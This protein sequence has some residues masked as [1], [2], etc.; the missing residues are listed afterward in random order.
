[1][2]KQAK[3]G[4]TKPS[5]PSVPTGSDSGPATAAD[6]FDPS[7]FRLVRADGLGLGRVGVVDIGSNTLRLVVYDVPTRLPIPMYNEKAQC[8][9]GRGMAETGKLYGPGVE[10]ALAS[11]D[12]FIRLAE[13]MGVRDLHLVATAAVRDASDG[14]E[15]VDTIYRRFARRVEVLSGAEEAQLAALGLLSGTR[16][17]DGLL[18]DLGGGSLD[19]VH[20]EKGKFGE[21][22]TFQLGHLALN[23]ASRGDPKKALGLVRK[24]LADQPLLA[25]AKGRNLYAVGGSL[26]ALARIFI[27]QTGYPLHV[28]DNYAIRGDEA[29]RLTRVLAGLSRG[30][31]E[32]IPGLARRRIDGL[33]YAAVVLEVLLEMLEPR[34]LIFSGFGMREGRLLKSLPGPMRD[35]DPL[36]AGCKTLAE[37]SG[38]FALSG[39]EV[40]DWLAPCFADRT[41]DEE[42]IRRAAGHLSDLGWSEH[43]DY[44]AWHAYQRVLTLPYAGLSHL[45]RARLALAIYTRY[46]G[47]VR[48]TRVQPIAALL[49]EKA[50]ELVES[51]GFGLR[52]AHTLSGSAPGVLTATGLKVD[53]KTLTLAPEDP[54]LLSETVQRRFRTFAKS[55]GLEPQIAG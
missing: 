29:L 34:Q 33:P 14:G 10:M 30:T 17:A 50:L 31:L 3:K 32:R 41:E 54:D 12:R 45:D 18:G 28:L 26:R 8:E 47:D 9:L 16:D 48:D 53:R 19:I 36:I 43:P 24:G 13:A 35:Q 20:L 55:L 52:F 22:D 11:L 49:D 42:R 6:I 23:E 37:H 38:R 27:D 5:G 51:I 2:A 15:F 21:Q 40:N 39:G 7:L 1:M 25:K 46:N 44:R 4:S